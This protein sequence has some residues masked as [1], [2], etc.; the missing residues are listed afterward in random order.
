M[1]NLLTEPIEVYRGDYIKVLCMDE[2]GAGGAHHL[3]HIYEIDADVAT[4]EPLTVIKHQEGAILENGVN[5]STN[6]AH[7][8]IVAHRLNCF[9]EGPFPSDFNEVALCGVDFAKAVL[10]MRTRVRKARNVEGRDKA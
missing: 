9:Q 2:Q 4:V 8:A 6:E 3:Y 1:A 7:L 5:G 10:K